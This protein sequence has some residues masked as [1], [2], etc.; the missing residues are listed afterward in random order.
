MIQ[1]GDQVRLP[2]AQPIEECRRPIS[3][4]VEPTP[5][6]NAAKLLAKYFDWCN[7]LCQF[8]DI[9]EPIVLTVS[10]YYRSVFQS[11]LLCETLLLCLTLYFFSPIRISLP[12]REI[13]Q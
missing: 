11:Y 9:N 7:Y 4:S 10:T 5:N 2:Q 8:N 1:S 12:C 6:A 13:F 3:N